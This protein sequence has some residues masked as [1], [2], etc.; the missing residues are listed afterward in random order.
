MNTNVLKRV[1]AVAWVV[2]AAASAVPAQANAITTQS[3]TY[4]ACGSYNEPDHLTVCSWSP[5]YMQVIKFSGIP[6][7]SGGC[8][9][10]A[11]AWVDF[12][13]STGSRKPAY[14]QGSCGGYRNYSLGTCA[15]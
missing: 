7:S 6:C 5:N 11:L 10:S 8:S 3:G 2:T 4:A 12:V 1:A 15:C 9:S 14:I 13:Y